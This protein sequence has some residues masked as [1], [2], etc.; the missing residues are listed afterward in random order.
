MSK[1]STFSLTD[2][3]G[4]IFCSKT[5]EEIP[6][7]KERKIKPREALIRGLKNGS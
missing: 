4:K 5:G 1:P 7:K 2:E 3:K 6:C